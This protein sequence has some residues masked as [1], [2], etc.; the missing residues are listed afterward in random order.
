MNFIKFSLPKWTLSVALFSFFALNGLA[1]NRNQH[2]ISNLETESSTFKSNDEKTPAKSACDLNV[3]VGAN[4]SICRGKSKTI[5]AT[6]TGGVLP[7]TFAW[8][9]GSV[10]PSVSAALGGS[11]SVTATDA[12]GCTAVAT[13]SVTVLDTAVF[14]IQIRPDTNIFLS[15]R[16]KNVI[17][18]AQPDGVVPV[19]GFNW[20]TG[21]TNIQFIEP[22]TPG[23]YTV[24][25]TA[26]N[27][28][29]SVGNQLVTQDITPPNLTLTRLG[30]NDSLSC[31]ITTIFL[32]AAAPSSEFLWNTGSVATTIAATAAGNYGVTATSQINGC[33]A[34]AS[35][36]IFF[37][38]NAASL[39]TSF[40]PTL[41]NGDKSTATLTAVGSGS[42][43]FSKNGGTTWQ[44]SNVF[45]N[46]AANTYTFAVRS[47][48]L[49]SCV[50]TQ[51]VDISQPTKLLATVEKTNV[52]CSGNIDGR[53]KITASG[54]TGLDSFSVNNGSIYF[55]NNTFGSLISGNYKVRV[56]DANGCTTAAQTVNLTQPTAINFNVSQVNIS[57]YGLSD[58]KITIKNRT[59]GNGSPYQ[60]SK[61]DGAT[62]QADTIFSGLSATIYNVK[63]KDV[64]GCT[65]TMKAASIS[66]PTPISFGITKQDITCSNATGV[67][68]ISLIGGGTTPYKYSKD[69]G[70]NFQ[71]S[72][73]F[74]NLPVGTYSIQVKDLKNCLSSVENAS[75]VNNCTPSGAGNLSAR[76]ATQFVP[77]VFQNIYPNP[78]ESYL[79]IDLS[80]KNEK[81]VEFQFFNVI[82][83]VVKAE[84]RNLEKGENHLEFDCSTLPSGVYQVNTSLGAGRNTPTLFVK[85]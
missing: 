82:G 69:G 35:K 85:L 14:S 37:K 60:F 57:C 34:T 40:T 6:T 70:L 81:E 52:T 76:T 67:V 83:K 43:Q 49:P 80:S 3:S 68:G 41:C 8:S 17:V 74:I 54:G 39:S 55:S 48:S 22:Q 18:K 19:V 66:Q 30:P 38:N 62:W 75:I 58:G 4:D 20:S 64:N 65:S 63:V 44:T 32:E 72:S 56:K 78:A 2:L 61:D 84:K 77:V 26:Q 16:N 23:L 50:S 79:I 27:G 28:C 29:Q 10:T 15:C 12:T 45:N 13:K 53:I 1:Q 46:L 7:I 42:L 71:T 36:Q 11:F 33:T 25:V 59:G 21:A 24:T 5:T 51:V 9:N 31:Q 73:I 47:A